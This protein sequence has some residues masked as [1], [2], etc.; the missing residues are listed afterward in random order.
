MQCRGMDILVARCF[1]ASYCQIVSKTIENI[2]C[3]NKENEMWDREDII[4]NIIN[5]QETEHQV[6]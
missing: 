3:Q 2:S 6:D 1:C 5:Q 4:I